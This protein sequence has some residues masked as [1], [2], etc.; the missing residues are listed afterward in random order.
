[1][2]IDRA[3]VAAVLSGATVAYPPAAMDPRRTR[4]RELLTSALSQVESELARPT[5]NLCPKQL[6]TCRD[7]LRG[8]LD[9][10]DADALPPKR[11]RQEGLCRLI[12]DSWPFDLPLGNAILQAERAF[13][14]C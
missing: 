9:A 14:N 8:Y 4:A 7:S 10:I 2:R 11:D 5:C 6:G 1:V 13:R 12:L 3:R